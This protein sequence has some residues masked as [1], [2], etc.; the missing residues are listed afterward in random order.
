MD[1]PGGLAI[2]SSAE[3]TNDADLQRE[4][5]LTE[6]ALAESERR[7]RLLATNATDLVIRA[8]VMGR[9]T[10]V[11]PSVAAVLG[12]DA[13]DLIDTSVIDLVH[14]DDR[15]RTQQAMADGLGTGHA[16]PTCFVCRS[17]GANGTWIWT[18]TMSRP[19]F[20]PDTG[21][22]VEVQSSIRDVTSR[23]EARNQLRFSER[24]FRSALASSPA[25]T[26]VVDLDHRAVLVNRSMAALLGRA[27]AELEGTDWRRWVHEPDR[28]LVAQ[29]ANTGWGGRVTRPLDLR[30][31]TPEGA[32]RWGRL[33]LSPLDLEPEPDLTPGA[34]PGWL[35][36]VQDVTV[37]RRRTELVERHNLHDGLGG[38]LRRQETDQ[39]IQDALDAGWLTVHYQPIVDLRTRRIVGHESLLRID[40]PERGLLAPS[41]FLGRAEETELIMPIGR[42]VL[43]ESI[44]RTGVRWALGDRTWV[45]I[46]VAGSQLIHDE[47]TGVVA[48]ALERASLPASAVHIE[49][50]ESTELLPDGTGRAEVGRLRALGCPIWLDDFGTGF[51]SLTYVRHLPVSG[52]KLDRTFVAGVDDDPQ[53]AAIVDAVLGLAE[54]LGLQVIAEGVESERQAMTLADLG[55]PLGQGYLFGRAVPEPGL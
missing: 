19:I 20:D 31:R 39:L 5:Y 55:C 6:E 13:R 14:P 25:A 28:P 12:Y 41:L 42:W 53:S 22:I 44:R 7:Y 4:L 49:V 54:G 33:T 50:T 46:N 3:P 29:M 36:Q 21:E 16:A 45:G 1:E 10:Y 40:H 9:I 2:A 37:E 38:R 30:F 15:A 27:P 51:S 11:S 47:L 35:V 23:V 32:V 34:E 26:A 48:E 8:N 17:R 52:L 18:E 24:R 43:E